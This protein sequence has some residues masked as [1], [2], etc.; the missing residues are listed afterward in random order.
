MEVLKPIKSEHL[1]CSKTKI[2]F[3]I[4][5]QYA[6]FMVLQNS[7]GMFTK[8]ALGLKSSESPEL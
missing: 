8:T 4:I 1:F 3:K 2:M 7:H 6:T 5:K